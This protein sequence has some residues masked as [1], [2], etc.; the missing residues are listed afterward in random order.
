MYLAL[1]VV[2]V[3]VYVAAH[4]VVNVSQRLMHE[5]TMNIQLIW[6]GIGVYGD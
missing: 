2:Y 4:D 1:D 5:Y 6:E 3:V